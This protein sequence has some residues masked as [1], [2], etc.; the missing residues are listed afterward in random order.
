MAINHLL[1]QSVTASRQ[2]ITLSDEARNSILTDTA[3]EL[4]KQQA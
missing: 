3:N 1:Q 2:L 4:L